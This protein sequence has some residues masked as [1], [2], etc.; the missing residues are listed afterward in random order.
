[1]YSHA[2]SGG[3]TVKF[4]A[5]KACYREGIPWGKI[6]SGKEYCAVCVQR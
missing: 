1:M 6:I 5:A 3:C 2:D 4:L